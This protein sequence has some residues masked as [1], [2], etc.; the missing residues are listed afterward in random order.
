MPV[1]VS[2]RLKPSAND[3]LGAVTVMLCRT[4]TLTFSAKVALTPFSVAVIVVEPGATASTT[5]ATLT[6]AAAGF[7]E[8]HCTDAL[9]FC[10]VPLL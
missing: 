5:P 10:V 2:C 7:D 8:L 1:A 6:V 3:E 9:I 4:A